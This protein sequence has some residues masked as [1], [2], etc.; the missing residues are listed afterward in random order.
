MLTQELLERV[1]AK[2]P[3]YQ[4]FMTVD[5]LDASS[6]R[7]AQEYPG[8]VS[9]T[10]I[11]KSRSGHPLLCDMRYGRGVRGQPV[12]LWGAV[13][14]LTHPTRKEPMTFVSAPRGDAFF[15]YAA[16][17]DGFLNDQRKGADL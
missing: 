1:L 12:A 7:L 3:D 5:E 4:T 11:G 17:I 16:L 9:L 15:S 13:L 10:E 14:S 8:V 2:V 6:R